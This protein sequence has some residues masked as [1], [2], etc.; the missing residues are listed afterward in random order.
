MKQRDVGDEYVEETLPVMPTLK[1]LDAF[2]QKLIKDLPFDP[3]DIHGLKAMNADYNLAVSERS[4]GKTYT[5]IDHFGF[6]RWLLSGGL[7]GGKPFVYT[8]RYS[9]EVKPDKVAKWT[10][11]FCKN[12]YVKFLT[13]GAYDR[14]FQESG[15]LYFGTYVNRKRVRHPDP[16][17]YLDAV[18][19]ADHKGGGDLDICAFFMDEFFTR[20]AYL[21]DEF[22]WFMNLLSTYVRFRDGIPVV[23][24]GNTV[25]EHGNPY[26]NEMGLYHLKEMKQGD[27]DEYSY[28]YDDG[29][30]MRLAIEYIKSSERGKPSDKY[31]A[32]D[33]PKLRMITGGEWEMDMYPHIHERIDK[34][35]IQFRFYIRYDRELV[36]GQ[37]VNKSG[38]VF[39]HF[40]PKSTPLKELETDLIY[41][42]DANF[43]RNWRVNLFKG[44][45]RGERKIQELFKIGKV[46]Y[47]TNRTGEIIRSYRQW[48]G[49]DV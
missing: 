25:N 34:S 42:P 36:E 1:E 40:V 23:L 3:W 26:V 35:E 4:D 19:A 10:V 31:F 33:N 6:E 29:K 9:L 11:P 49:Q 32:F 46:F 38:N 41:S 2:R 13:G 28:P 17:C 15:A 43:R 47:A 37:I 5:A 44:N 14:I 45:L 18:G 8:R 21:D 48:C 20:G 24:L 7:Y 12:G 30:V 16:F 39:L 27:I 22:V